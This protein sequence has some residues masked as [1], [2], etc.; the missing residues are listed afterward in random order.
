M[1]YRLVGHGELAKVV[2]DHVRLDLDG[3]ELLAVVDANDAADHLGEDDH[4]A[5]VCLDG[6]GLL[7]GLRQPLGLSQALEEVL[8]LL[9]EAA[10]DELATNAG[11]EEG[12]ELLSAHVDQLLEINSAVGVLAKRASLVGGSG[13]RSVSHPEFSKESIPSF[14]LVVLFVR[15]SPSF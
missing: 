9:L 6:R 2:A 8:V 1:L 5:K 3:V 4:V 13:S 14:F 7:V 15:I 12:S 10:N 11:R